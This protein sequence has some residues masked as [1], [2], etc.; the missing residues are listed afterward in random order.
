MARHRIHGVYYDAAHSNGPALALWNNE[1][2]IEVVTTHA[3]RH[4]DFALAEPRMWPRVIDAAVSVGMRA[5][6]MPRCHL[7]PKFGRRGE[8][9]LRASSFC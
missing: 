2:R 4:K 6:L 7:C 5:D 8:H 9:A 3:G 1:S